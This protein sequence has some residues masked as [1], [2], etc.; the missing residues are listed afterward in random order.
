[1][2]ALCELGACYV[3]VIYVR[4]CARFS[5]TQ[6][7]DLVKI[8]LESIRELIWWLLRTDFVASVGN[9]GG[10]MCENGVR[11]CFLGVSSGVFVAS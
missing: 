11:R 9:L 5:A 8:Q 1:M 2:R 3:C 10:E 6:S 4:A 7:S